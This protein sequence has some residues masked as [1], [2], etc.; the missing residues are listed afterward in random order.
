MSSKSS[1]WEVA[2]GEGGA[3]LGTGEGRGEDRA[4]V[5]PTLTRLDCSLFKIES[6]ELTIG[7]DGG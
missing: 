4:E 3:G 2:T 1:C 7:R 6:K 5:G